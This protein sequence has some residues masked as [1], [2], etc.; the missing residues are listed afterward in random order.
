MICNGKSKI[1]EGDPA[2]LVLVKG[3]DFDS[4]L[5]ARPKERIIIKNGEVIHLNIK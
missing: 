3:G 4:V 1:M 5:C 2:D